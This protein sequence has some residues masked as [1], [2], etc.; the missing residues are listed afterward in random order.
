MS[1]DNGT[2]GTGGWT[3]P[4]PGDPDNN[5]NINAV[6]AFGG[7]D[8]TWSYPATYPYAVSY[9]ILYRGELDNFF[10]AAEH[11]IVTGGFFYDKINEDK[12][13]YYWIRLVSVN[14]T[15]AEPVGPATAVA[16]PT[17]GQLIEDLTG[18]IDAG[19]LSQTLKNQLDQISILN[20]NLLNEITDRQTGQTTL[21]QAMAD[22]EE[23]TADALTFFTS[24][25]NSLTNADSA[26]VESI[27]L[28][29]AT[30]NGNIASVSTNLTA[31]IQEVDGQ[32]TNIGA[33]YTVN[34]NVNGL[35]GGFGI[36]NNGSV[37]QAGFDVDE[38]YVGKTQANK[39]KPFIISGG[40]VYIDEAA[41]EKLTFTKLRSADG[42]FI[43]ADGKV[44]ADYLNVKGLTVT[45]NLGQVSFAVDVNGDS[46]FGGTLN[47]K[48]AASGERV[49]Q[50]NQVYKVIDAG[51]VVR[52]K[53][54]N[55]A[56]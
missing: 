41:I 45:N 55:L 14:G 42:S 24:Q 33:L 27:D 3:G 54:G 4:L 25:V 38:F 29:A 34:V 16:K 18:Q 8:V 7:I 51:G 31:M 30:L 10:G 2:C 39:R 11:A 19:L 23:G 52:V 21:A 32:V 6:P 1:C 46:T 47:I 53:L 56:A 9:G 35:V 15:I 5:I 49:E 36:Y 40:V 12:R 43:V 22:V 20:T 26:I 17:I 28:A 13:Y 37:I 50:T 44:K 48:S